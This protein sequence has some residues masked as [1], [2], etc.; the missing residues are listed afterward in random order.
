[1]DVST[2]NIEDI[3]KYVRA[4]Y[5]QREG[6]RQTSSAQVAEDVRKAQQTIQNSRPTK[7]DIKNALAEA[8]ESRNQKTSHSLPQGVDPEIQDLINAMNG[9]KISHGEIAVLERYPQIGPLLRGGTNY[10]YFISHIVVDNGARNGKVIARNDGSFITNQPQNTNPLK[11]S[12]M[13]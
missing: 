2:Y 3:Y 4:A 11:G 7:D 8:R 10:A 6:I 5:Y 12:A 9:T 13:Q 1:M